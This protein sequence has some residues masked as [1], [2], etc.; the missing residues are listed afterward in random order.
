MRVTHRRAVIYVAPDA[1]FED[2]FRY[3]AQV[4]LGRP[5]TGHV[6]SEDRE[7]LVQGAFDPRAATV[8]VRQKAPQSPGCWGL[9]PS[10]ALAL[11]VHGQFYIAPARLRLYGY[12]P[13][14]IEPRR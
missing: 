10:T 7:R 4:V 12:S 8:R 14:P 9:S 6:V 13:R 2:H 5:P 1:R 3:L 11:T